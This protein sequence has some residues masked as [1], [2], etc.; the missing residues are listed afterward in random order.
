[1]IPVA[2]GAEVPENE[3]HLI[4]LPDNVADMTDAELDALAERIYN[5]VMGVDSE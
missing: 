5:N 2:E 3:R 1:M 4:E